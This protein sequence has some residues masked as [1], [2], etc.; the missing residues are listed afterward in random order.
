MAAF[1]QAINFKLLSDRRLG[2]RAKIGERPSPVDQRT[3][4]KFGH[5][6]RVHPNPSG[7]EHLLQVG[8]S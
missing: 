1:N 8:V 2:Q 6:K 4:S 5:N 7:A 3:E